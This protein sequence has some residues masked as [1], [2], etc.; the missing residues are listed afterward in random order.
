[1]RLGG[2]QPG[3]VIGEGGVAA[4]GPAELGAGTWI[5]LP[6]HGLIRLAFDN[7]AW[8]EA[9]GLSTGPPPPAGR[10]PG[11]GGVEIVT[12]SG[13]TGPRLSLGLPDVAE[14][15]ALGDGDHH[16]QPAASFPAGIAQPRDRP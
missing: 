11:Q 13:V 4:A 12:A 2:A 3:Q 7:L 6:V 9:E 15:V 5:N 10:L 1:V 8:G 16:G 14:V